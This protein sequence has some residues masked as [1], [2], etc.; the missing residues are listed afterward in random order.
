M[1]WGVVG[2]SAQGL[3]G[4][5]GGNVTMTEPAGAASG[6]LMVAALA[7]IGTT[8]FTAPAGWTLI[9][10]SINATASF[11]WY[12]IIRGGS[13]PSLIWTRTGG[14]NVTGRITA[15]SASAA[16][17]FI[18]DTAGTPTSPSGLSHGCAGVTTTG[19]SDLVLAFSVTNSGSIVANDFDATDPG[20]A[21]GT[22][23]DASTAPTAGTWKLRYS[24]LRAVSSPHSFAFADAVRT[25]AGATGDLVVTSASNTVA[26]CGIAAF[27]ES[28]G[29]GGGGSIAV[30]SNYYRMMRGS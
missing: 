24:D 15:Y 10:E 5:G 6:H 12:Y 30:I 18:N 21:S 4:S 14:S 22:T 27:T 2:V 9:G 7:F 23:V 25:S 16:I 11:H 26:S 3:T 20:T 28:G 8:T 29:G 13:A 1:T 19:T 17:T